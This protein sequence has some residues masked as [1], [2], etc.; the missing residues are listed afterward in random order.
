M[1]KLI[2]TALCLLAFTSCV[3]SLWDSSAGN[4]GGEGVLALFEDLTAADFME[5]P[6]KEVS[7]EEIEGNIRILVSLNGYGKSRASG[8]IEIIFSGRKEGN[9]LI[10]ERYLMN[11]SLTALGIPVSIEDAA[12]ETEAVIFSIDENTPTLAS[13]GSLKYPA[14][15]KI[16]A[17]DEDNTAVVIFPE[18]D[19]GNL[20]NDDIQAIQAAA[21]NAL[22][23]FSFIPEGEATELIPDGS[24]VFSGNAD[25]SWTLHIEC[26]KIQISISSES[27][28]AGINIDGK[29]FSVDSRIVLARTVI[30][31]KMEIDI[32]A[33]SYL[34]EF[35]NSNLI[36]TLS[37]LVNG[38][39]SGVITLTAADLD[40]SAF[41]A[42]LDMDNF[43]IRGKGI[44]VS[45]KLFL[46]LAGKME[47]GILTAGEYEAVSDGL[48]FKEDDR[49]FEIA[50]EAVKGMLDGEEPVFFRIKED[51]DSLSAERSENLILGL[52]V[53]GR[54]VYSN[55]T[56]TF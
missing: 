11:G 10:A 49:E 34:E 38:S 26:G 22:S 24:A 2:F 35:R 29:T 27:E 39:L 21:E 18:D 48:I 52:P 51:G 7:P 25:G 33:S 28:E 5:N 42:E 32:I 6:A 44:T 56:L 53:S 23:Q 17:G 9:F 8:E 43:G 47:S 54:A 55:R 46:T 3:Q 45:G 13:T 50:L 1:R 14:T 31:E 4:D 30:P 41:L 16:R 15:G 37:D 19:K 36:F 40:G 12:S 20:T